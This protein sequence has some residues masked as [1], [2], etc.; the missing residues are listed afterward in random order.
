MS[1]SS[2]TRKVIFRIGGKQEQ[3]VVTRTG[4]TAESLLKVLQFLRDDSNDPQIQNGAR[5]MILLISQT[6]R[7]SIRNVGITKVTVSFKWLRELSARVSSLA[8]QKS[9]QS[10]WFVVA[11]V[12]EIVPAETTEEVIQ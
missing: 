4:V 12:K 8:T 9:Q 5:F 2:N 6:L 11:F 10:A 7:S 3:L 1:A